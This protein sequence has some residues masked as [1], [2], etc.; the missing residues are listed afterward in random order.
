LCPELEFSRELRTELYR[1]Q[2]FRRAAVTPLSRGVSEAK[3]FPR[4]VLSREAA[5]FEHPSI[6]WGGCVVTAAEAR[7]C[8][9]TREMPVL[10]YHRIAT[11]GPAELAPYRIAP[12]NFEG[13][14][15]WLQRY[16]F[17]SVSLDEFFKLWFARNIREVPGKPI[18]LTF[19]DAYADFYH[20]AWPLLRRYGF[21]ATVFV[22]TD[23]VGGSADWDIS[24]GSPAQIMSWNE[25]TE[26]QKSGIHFGSHSCRHKRLTDLSKREVL[27]DAIN[28]KT[29]L[30]QKLGIDVSGYS[31]PWGSA[32]LTSRLLIAQAQYKF[33]VGGTRGNR[34]N[35]DDPFYIPRIEVLGSDT[36][37]DFIAKLREPEA[38]EKSARLKYQQLRLKRDRATY[39]GR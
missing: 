30:E 39:M 21:G 23:Y 12:E 3:A 37:E 27:V 35:L 31:Y 4:E 1:V 16:G 9:V 34:S 26:L 33:A 5:D 24:Y 28:S 25:I 10:M 6:K 14:L 13:Q 18:V 32:D 22:P 2:L 38:A 17:H 8:W 11:D 7:H 29:V 15:A 36:L 20:N 19:D